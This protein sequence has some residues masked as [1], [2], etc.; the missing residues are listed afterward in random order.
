MWKQESPIG[1]LRIVPLSSGRYGFEYDGTI[2]ESCTP[3][4]AQADDIYMHVTGCDAW[5]FL[6]GQV[7][8]C[9]CELSGWERIL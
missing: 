7:L 6:D 3:P 9:P 2:W 5:D 4:E 1:T 8:D